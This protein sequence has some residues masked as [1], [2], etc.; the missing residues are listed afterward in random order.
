VIFRGDRSQ[1]V[2]YWFK[3]GS[4][5]TGNY[6]LNTLNWVLGK[7]TF[8]EPSSSMIRLSTVIGRQGDEVS[9]RVLEDFALQFEPILLEKVR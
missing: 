8:G 3:T 4:Q 1:A 5:L 9:F 2:L 6:F 7:I